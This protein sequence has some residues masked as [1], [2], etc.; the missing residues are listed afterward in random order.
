MYTTQLSAAA[1]QILALAARTPDD[2]LSRPTPCDPMDLGALY[3][4]V[5]GLSAAFAG[6]ARKDDGPLTSTP[7]DPKSQ[8]LPDDWRTELMASLGDL[9]AAW[10]EPGAWDGMTKAGGVT[11]P[12][13][14]L[15]LVAVS[16][17]VLHGWDVARSVGVEYGAD[18]EVLQVVYNLHYPPEP[19]SQRDGMFG[20][21]VPVPED[22][23]LLDRLVALAG[24]DPFWPANG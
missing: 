17:L 4:H 18:D 3:A 10:D 1:Q 7:P 14:I 23:P 5:I 11:A 15:G 12:A 6:A 2:I 13:S 24:R 20:P 19:Q 16:E 22:A 21:I 8:V 9:C